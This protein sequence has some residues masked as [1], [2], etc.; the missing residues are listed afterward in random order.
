VEQG[1]T[2]SMFFN[3]TANHF[4]SFRVQYAT[5]FANVETEVDVMQTEA[6]RVPDKFNSW[7]FDEAT[8]WYRFAEDD[9]TRLQYR[10]NRFLIGQRK[11][12]K[13]FLI[14]RPESKTFLNK[15]AEYPEAK[16]LPDGKYSVDAFSVEKPGNVDK[17]KKVFL[18]TELRPDNSDVDITVA[19]DFRLKTSVSKDAELTQTAGAIGGQLALFTA[20]MGYVKPLLALYFLVTICE[21]LIE[22]HNAAFRAE[23]KNFLNET[24]KEVRASLLI[25]SQKE[26]N[27]KAIEGNS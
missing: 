8:N 14:F 1:T 7:K 27:G 23:L 6:G 25:A 24:N 10:G 11:Q 15:P 20:F 9:Q 22:R 16:A 4:N 21:I 5:E 19:L 2:S 26:A 13:A 3:D 12:E 18:N 17:R